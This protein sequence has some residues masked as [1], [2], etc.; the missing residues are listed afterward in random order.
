MALTA[1]D[2]RMIDEV[3]SLLRPE[4]RLLFITGAGLSAD[5]G[6][7]TYR[8]TGGLYDAG[9][10]TRHGVSIEEALSGWM[11]E[12]EPEVTWEYLHE[13]ERAARGAKPN[14]GHEVIA[15]LEGHFRSVWTLT[16]N[17]DG[18]HRQA[19]SRHIIDIHGDLRAILCTRCDYRAEV[20]DYAHLPPLPRCPSCGAAARP[21]VVLFGE[22]LP[23]RKLATLYRELDAG[24]DVVLAVGTSAVFPYIA[25]PVLWARSAGIPTVEINPSRTRLSDAVDFRIAAGAA[26]ALDRLWHAYRGGPG[27]P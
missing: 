9:R 16:Q 22:V 7:P 18:L 12:S 15:A 13:I 10:P 25:E 14:R 20:A 1:A 27:T 11:L 19:G 17:I 23:T 3:R 2:E 24:F 5:S 6:L 4:Q 8:G 21:D 26:E